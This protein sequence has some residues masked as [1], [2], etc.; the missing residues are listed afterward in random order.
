MA[1]FKTLNSANP[2]VRRPLRVSDLQDLWDGLGTIF[3]GVP[4]NTVKVVSGFELGD[5]NTVLEGVLIYNHKLYYYEGGLA[6]LGG[7]IYLYDVPS[8]LR[9]FANGQTQDFSFL[10]VATIAGIYDDGL[11][12]V[13]LTPQFIKD[14]LIGDA[15]TA[16]SVTTTTLQNGAV[17]SAKL[18]TGA[19][20]R[21]MLATR[22][23]L[24]SFADP[25][26]VGLED[27]YLRVNAQLN[28]RATY[29][30]AVQTGAQT[31]SVT[32]DKVGVCV[33]D[34]VNTVTADPENYCTITFEVYN[35]LGSI[36]AEFDFN[37]A[38]KTSGKSAIRLTITS[39]E[40]SVLGVTYEAIDVL[41]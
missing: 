27:S 19:V 16:G 22:T 37:M 21:K 35:S 9:V 8:D 31:Q 12:A 30:F 4:E 5:N 32:T 33:V 17:T 14:R 26:Q 34:I 13:E 10:N 25:I 20:S 15:L 2:S 28:A 11:V 39:N 41:I 38:I 23:S 18:A 7:R 29:S 1:G 3:A 6:M 36:V 40:V 24:P